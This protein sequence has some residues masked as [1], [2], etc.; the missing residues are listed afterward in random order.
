MARRAPDYA[1]PDW[2]PPGTGREICTLDIDV[3][4][5]MF[6]GGYEPRIVDPESVV[7][8]PQVRGYLRFWWRAVEA[9]RLQTSHELFEAESRLWG[10]AGTCGEVAVRVGIRDPGRNRRLQ[11]IIA[12]A[13]QRGAAHRARWQRQNGPVRAR[14]A[15]ATDPGLGYFLFPFRGEQKNKLEEARGREGVRFSLVVSMSEAAR[16]QVERALRAWLAFGGVGARTRRGCGALRGPGGWQPPSRDSLEAWLTAL[17][18]GVLRRTPQ[19]PSLASATLLLCPKARD[20]TDAWHQLATFWARFRKGHVGDVPYEPRRGG[21]WKDYATLSILTDKR[22]QS[23]RLNKPFLGLPII[24]QPFQNARFAGTLK[25]ETSG[26]MA[27]PVILKP[28]VLADGSVHPLI[29]VLRTLEPSGIRV[30]ADR[31]DHKF[32]LAPNPEDPVLMRL[33]ADHPVRA[34][35]AAAKEHWPNGIAQFRTGEDP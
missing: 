31:L 14:K 28:V 12:D 10:A 8:A 15:G 11:D 7:R 27:S 30:R 34:V 24:Y 23:L 17:A 25:P 16:P 19:V 29:L 5:P 13:E 26:R 35:V 3:I 9:A 2:Q 6:G 1:P 22:L 33:G 4:T 20:A 32:R 18:P 21:H